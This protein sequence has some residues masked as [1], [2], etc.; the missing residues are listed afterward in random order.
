MKSTTQSKII[1]SSLLASVL[2]SLC[3]IAPLLALLGGA[4]GAFAAFNWVELLRPYL[5]GLTVVLLAAAWYQRLKPAKVTA[6]CAC[7][8]EEKPSLV[9]SNK[10]LLMV[11][12]MAILFLSFPYYA[13]GFDREPANNS[14]RQTGF[15]QTVQ[16]QVK[17]M[18]CA[19]CE[20]HVNQEVGKV[21]GVFGVSTSYK[22][23]SA[24]VTYDSTKVKP[25]Q[26]VEAARKTGYKVSVKGKE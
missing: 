8:D 22:A 1:G 18:T 13:D 7:K 3:C 24:T 4:T 23:G 14:M 9:K 26:I 2:A 15:Q 10:F 19:G 16:L 11:S 25:Q 12:F 20:A 6:D 21:P 5:I 17:G